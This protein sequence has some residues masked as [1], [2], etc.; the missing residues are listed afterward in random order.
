MRG[1]IGIVRVDAFE[2]EV[3]RAATGDSEIG[4]GDSEVSELVQRCLRIRTLL[5]TS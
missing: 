5:Y 2:I 4:F 3:L 1:L